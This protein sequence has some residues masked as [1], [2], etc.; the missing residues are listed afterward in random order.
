M[1]PTNL[2]FMRIRQCNA[3]AIY[4]KIRKRKQIRDIGVTGRKIELS[5]FFTNKEA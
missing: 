2:D 4:F 3:S 5:Y 1:H